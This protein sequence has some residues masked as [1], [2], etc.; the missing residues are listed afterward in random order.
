VQADGENG[1]NGKFQT[2]KQEFTALESEFNRI[3]GI[4]SQINASLVPVVP[5][6]TLTFA[7]SFSP[8]GAD[9]A[10]VLNNGIAAKATGQTNTNG[11]LSLQLP[12]GTRIQSMTIIGDKNGN[13]G[14][15]TVQ[16]LRQGI[17][18]NQTTLSGISLAAQPDA[19]NVSEPIPT[20]NNLVDNQTFK[21][22]VTAR[23]VGADAAAS[24]RIFALQFVC[25]QP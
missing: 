3:A 7:P 5:T 23:I 11:W 21:Y 4:V 15:F 19:F 17:S 9:P 10:W 8:N 6:T 12:N 20:V 13:V 25:G 24:A 22:I 18:G 1:F 16:L 2:L 14:S